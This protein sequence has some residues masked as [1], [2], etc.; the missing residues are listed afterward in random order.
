MQINLIKNDTQINS[1]ASSSIISILSNDKY[2]KSS[3]FL[4]DGYFRKS[5]YESRYEIEQQL[6]QTEFI[7]TSAAT[8]LALF[9]VTSF[10]PDN[11]VISFKLLQLFDNTN[12][13]C[14]HTIKHIFN[15]II[16]FLEEHFKVSRF[17]TSL[18]LNEKSGTPVI[19]ENMALEAT[20]SGQ[21]FLDGQYNDLCLFGYNKR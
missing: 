10:D 4:F 1:V 15:S 12:T 20:L 17:C 21:V 13:T 14:Q 11:E 9:K 19:T 5:S 7:L 16:Q 3:Y 18:L 2:I 8:S 6:N